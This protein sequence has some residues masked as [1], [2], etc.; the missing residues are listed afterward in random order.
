MKLVES[1]R[2]NYKVKNKAK[3]DRRS[4]PAFILL[5][6]AFCLLA[7]PSCSSGKV[8]SVSPSGEV[9]S[10]NPDDKAASPTPSNS[11]LSGEVKIDG[12][13]SLFLLSD[14]MAE[15][16]QKSN[17]SVK[18][19][20]NS[21]ST[22]AGFKKFCAG[23]TDISNASRPIKLEEIELCQKG[24]IEYIELPISADGIVV[25]VNPK[26]KALAPN[27]QDNTVAVNPQDNTIAVNPQD[28]TVAVNPKK[29]ALECLKVEE[30]KRIW[31]PSAQ[32]SMKTW[33]QIN[34]K[35]TKKPIALFGPGKDSGTYDFFTKKIIG[36][37][38]KSRTDYT[39][40]Q[41]DNFLVLNVAADKN[42][43]GFFSYAY[44]ES[45]KD[46]LKVVAIDSGK[47]CINPSPDTINDG[48]YQPLS[49]PL[50]IYVKKEAV[51]RPEV[52]AFVDFILSTNSKK[53][54]SETGY[55]PLPEELAK[56]VQQRFAD[57]KVGSRFEGKESQV[58]VTIKDLM[59]KDKKPDEKK[60]DEKKPDEKKP[61]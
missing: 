21:S 25:V 15:A 34:S 7:L 50:F 6:F 20:V 47:G 46:K 3:V 33:D 2:N 52:K 8:P 24:K 39:T 13:S 54:F 30:L 31:A 51:S 19:T 58:G 55:I 53:L 11:G 32:G 43:M 5:P 49:R 18:V 10:G 44:Y 22:G 4:L 12:S 14:A 61:E 45:N 37:E 36:E 26:N 29:K 56:E 40:N 60:P 57:G 38:G 42:A 28:N 17:S 27:A 16:F 59:T 41:D 9:G 48:T 23:E 35:F 1:G